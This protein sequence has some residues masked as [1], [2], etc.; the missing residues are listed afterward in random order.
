MRID[1]SKIAVSQHYT[2]KI[3]DGDDANGVAN[4]VG[5]LLQQNFDNYPGLKAWTHSDNLMYVMISTCLSVPVAMVIWF[6]RRKWL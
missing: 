6:K 2:V 4:I 1:V 5:T 3:A